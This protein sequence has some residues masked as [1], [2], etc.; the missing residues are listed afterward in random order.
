MIEV[1]EPIAE[2]KGTRLSIQEYLTFER[3]SLQKHEYFQGEVFA[4]SGASNRHSIIQSNL[5]IKL[6]M[7]LKGKSCRPLGSDMRL[8]LPSNSLFT[9]PDL[10]I[11][12]G[13]LHLLDDDNA[14]EPTIIIE[15]LSPST[16]SYDRGDKFKL[17]RDIKSL[18][19]YLLIDAESMS[20]EIFRYN[21][22]KHW[23]L[24]E[25]NLPEQSVSLPS[26]GISFLVSDAYDGTRLH[27]SNK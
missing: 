14:M 10:A 16:K 5:F 21:Q 9:Y 20:I 19:E 22:S 3:S 25:Y 24:E 1:R 17:Y 27:N 18:R 6:G 2:Y 15:I 8:H 26:I 13:E 23:E 11:Y 12:C 4:M 7:L